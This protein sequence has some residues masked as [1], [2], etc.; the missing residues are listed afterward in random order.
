M[1][2]PPKPSMPGPVTPRAVWRWRPA[3]APAK[4][5]CWCRACCAPCWT[6]LS[7]SRS[8]PSRSPARPR[9]KCGPD[10]KSGCLAFPVPTAPQHS[11]TMRSSSAECLQLKRHKLK[12]C[13]LAC[14]S[15][16]C[17]KAAALKSTPST[18]GLPNCSATPRWRCWKGSSC[19]PAMR[20]LKTPRSWKL[21]SFGASMPA[22][23]RMRSCA[24]CTS[25]WF[26]STVEPPCSTG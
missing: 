5:G 20:S 8:S 6:A 2:P 9:A 7:R 21:R 1:R 16:C 24:R 22:S 4:P 18:P 26:S 15:A 19:L 23:S 10:W 14:T 11:V 3:R 25:P 17:T 12:P 13:W